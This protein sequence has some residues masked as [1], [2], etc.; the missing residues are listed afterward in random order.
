MNWKTKYKEVIIALHNKGQ[1]SSE[2]ADV[3][4]SMGDELPRSVERSI[5]LL[6]NKWVPKQLPSEARI[7]VY[8]IE[9]SQAEFKLWWPGKQYVGYNAM[10]KEPQ[11]ISIA[12]KWLG[13][14]K[15]FTD[16]WDMKTHSDRDL[17]ERFLVEYNK[18]DMVI[19]QNN[20][21]FDN[22]WINARALKHSLYVN[23]HIRSFDIMK[24]NKR[25]FRLPSYSMKFMC[26]FLG[27]TL[28]QNHEGI[29]MWNM[30]EDG[31]S[32]QQKEYMRKMLDYNIGDIVSTEEMYYKIRPYMGNMIHVGALIGK[33]KYS[34]PN[35]GG[36]DIEL[37]RT[38][39]TPAG[40]VQRIMTCKEDNVEFRI[41]N[42]LYLKNV[43]IPAV[44]EE[45]K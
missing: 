3:L 34:C 12:W 32:A 39:T 1:S 24:Q 2:I 40:T 20:D 45:E 35:C 29:H 23:T 4:R 10:T 28:K 16:Y 26:E 27:I 30:V 13:E 37:V 44:E 33:G 19:G 15:V 43:S 9:T 7:M 38:T 14:D 8:D 11:I 21:R 22:R 17:M 41:T 31:T 42:A 25:L 6:V 5:R 36:E 18:A